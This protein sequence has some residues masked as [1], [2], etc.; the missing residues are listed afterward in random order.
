MAIKRKLKRFLKY[1]VIGVS[2][3]AIDLFLLYIFTDLFNWNYIISTGAAF[4]VAIS[5]NYFFSRHYV[6]HGT[7]TSIHKGYFTFMAIASMGIAIAMWGMEIL[8]GIFHMEF[9]DSRV[10]IAAI[11]GIW[12]YIINLYVNFRVSDKD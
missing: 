10:I 3:F 8:V 7:L 5:I 11:V 1:M 2:T 6:F 12:N 4:T 9:L